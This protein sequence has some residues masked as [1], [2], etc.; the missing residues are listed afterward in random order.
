MPLPE[1]FL[2]FT[3]VGVSS[4]RVAISGTSGPVTISATSF[5]E[6]LQPFFFMECILFFLWRRV[7]IRRL[8]VVVS[9]HLRTKIKIHIVDSNSKLTE[10]FGM[11]FAKNWTYR[12]PEIC[13]NGN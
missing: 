9:R 11:T 3:S 4:S 7:K 5:L 10:N 2:E 8:V 13:R 6:K 1:F 12:V